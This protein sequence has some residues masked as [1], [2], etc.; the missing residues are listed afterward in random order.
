MVGE[1]GYLVAIDL[2]SEGRLLWKAHPPEVGWAFEGSPL[3]EG[4][5]VY[6]AIRRSD[7][8]PQAHVACL[9]AETGHIRWRRFVVAAETP[10]RGALHETTHNLLT[11]DHQTIYYNSNLGAVAAISAA[12]GELKWV[13]LYPR[14]CKGDLLHPA[15]HLSRD[16]N[17]CLLDRGRL[18]VAPSDSPRIFALDAATGHILWQTSTALDSVVHL[19][20]TSDDHLIASGDRLYW[21]SL[22]PEDAGRI[23]RVWPDS[24]EKLGYG[25][26]VI[27]EDCIWWPTREKIY[28]LDRRTARLKKAIELVPRGAGGGNLLMVSQ[29]SVGA[30]RLL[31]ATHDELVALGEENLQ[32][33]GANSRRL[34]AAGILPQASRGLLGPGY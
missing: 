19:L 15:G 3:V 5:N 24:N 17:P 18:Y 21:I 22:K 9:D 2:E 11:M 6:V 1:A 7:I 12:A 32:N 28:V 29:P 33:N 31:I 26:G 10:A 13:S 23:S 20:G 34:T 16:L 25:R 30:R 27:S 14:D 8:R 4:P